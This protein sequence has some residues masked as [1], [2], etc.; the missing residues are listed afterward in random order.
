[1]CS[2]ILLISLNIKVEQFTDE[3]LEVIQKER[4]KKKLKA[5]KLQTSTKFLQKIR[6]FDDIH[7]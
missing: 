4:E 1:M 2:E 5:E 3:E 6:K 7:L